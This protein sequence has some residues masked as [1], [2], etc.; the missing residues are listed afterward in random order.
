MGARVALTCRAEPPVIR[1]VPVTDDW[2]AWTLYIT[3]ASD[4]DNID[5]LYRKR[6]PHPHIRDYRQ[7]FLPSF[8]RE[9]WSEAFLRTFEPTL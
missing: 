1:V 2:T 4:Q 9:E 3:A 8:L 7:V 6:H 5:F